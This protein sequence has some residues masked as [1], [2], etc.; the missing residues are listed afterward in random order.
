MPDLEIGC[1]VLIGATVFN[2]FFALIGPLLSRSMVFELKSLSKEEILGILERAL[3]D[4]ERGL[5]NLK[6]KADEKALK[7]LAEVSEGDARRALNA[8]ELGCLTTSP[9]KKGI[10]QWSALCA[11]V[12]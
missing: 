2:P 4:K 7:F 8:I 6:I 10:I 3:S 9:D 12:C 11:C 5:G 1:L